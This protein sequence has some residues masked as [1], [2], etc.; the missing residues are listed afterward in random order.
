[1]LREHVQ[2]PYEKINFLESWRN[3]PEI[4]TSEEIL[5]DVSWQDKDGPEQPMD[6]QSLAE[7]KEF[8]PRLP[9]NIIDQAWGSKEEY[10]GFHYQILREDAV[11]PLR[12]SV[13]T[14]KRNDDMSDTQDT[15][16]YT[17]VCRAT[18]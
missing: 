1:M 7:P 10:L 9:H 17:D 15:S 11:A 12:Q 13:A 5:K 14:F 4:P 8:D 2:K 16:I 3:Q 18:W 6:Y